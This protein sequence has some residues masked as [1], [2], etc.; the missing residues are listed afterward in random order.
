[1]PAKPVRAT[2]A[3]SALRAKRREFRP[4]MNVSP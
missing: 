3:V 4:D 1:M 2:A